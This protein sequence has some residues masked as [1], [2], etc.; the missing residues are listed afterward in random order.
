MEGYDHAR[1]Q[2]IV[3][4][5]TAQRVR[6]AVRRLTPSDGVRV[7]GSSSGRPSRFGDNAFKSLLSAGVEQ[8]FTITI[9]LVAELNPAICIISD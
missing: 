4:A 1:M 7:R 3:E 8:G 5:N 6:A 2:G 9:E